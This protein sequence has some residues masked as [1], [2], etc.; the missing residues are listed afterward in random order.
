MFDNKTIL[1]YPFNR[2]DEDDACAGMTL[3]ESVAINET[4][5]QNL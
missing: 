4:P 2:F 3:E 5:P 1:C